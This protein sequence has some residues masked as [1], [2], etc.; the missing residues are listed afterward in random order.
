MIFAVTSLSTSTGIPAV[1]SPFP[2]FVILPVILGFPVPLIAIA[3][4]SAFA[5]SQL[6]HF[7]GEPRPKPNLGFTITLGLVTGLTALGLGFGWPYGL[8][9][10]GLTY[11]VVVTA[12]NLAFAIG[13]WSLWWV[14]R[15]AGR[16]R[17][18]VLFGFMLF[19]WVFWYA[20]PY[21]GEI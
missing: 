6:H 11:C 16:Y 12:A 9:Y 18:Q 7:K 17:S 14:T 21:M 13:T 10:Q 8:D 4:S 3:A 5:L 20:L 1:Y 19:A 15:T 2:L